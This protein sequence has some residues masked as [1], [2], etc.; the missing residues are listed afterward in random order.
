MR[1]HAQCHPHGAILTGTN[2]DDFISGT[3]GPDRIDGRAGNDTLI[4]LGGNDTLLGGDGDDLMEGGPGNDLM[5]GGAGNDRLSGD[6]G[7]DT[8]EG[9]AGDDDFFLF[10][11]GADRISGDGGRDS[12]HLFTATSADLSR[13]K[14]VSADGTA[15]LCGIEN[16]FGSDQNDRLTGDGAANVLR[17]DAGDDRLSGLGGN[18]TLVGDAGADTMTGG[19]GADSFA[20]ASFAGA[21]RVT[22]FRSGVD[23]LA[24]F[25]TAELGAEGDFAPNDPRFFA[26]AGATAGHDASDRVIYDTSAGKVY[27]DPD[28]SGAQVSM[29]MFTLEGRPA[30]AATDITVH[31]FFNL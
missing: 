19:A 18:D 26:A 8:M 25:P 17:G 16:L 1:P 11:G 3:D 28:G 24:L 4:G 29:L 15:S 5:K 13:G 2:G 23:E 20:W 21:E 22:D 12:V 10:F 7:N 14:L 9:G 30:L 27:Y 31:N 6:A